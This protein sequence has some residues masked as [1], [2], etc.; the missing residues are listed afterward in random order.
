MYHKLQ[1]FVSKLDVH[2][3]ASPASTFW[4]SIIDTPPS[5]LRVTDGEFQRGRALFL[6]NSVQISQSL[7]FFSLAGGFASPRIV[8]TLEA[9]SYLVPSPEKKLSSASKDRTYRRLL[10]TFQFVLDVMKCFAPESDL[11]GATH[12]LPGGEGWKSIIRVRMLHGIARARVQAKVYHE[13]DVPR[14]LNDVPISQEDISATQ[15]HFPRLFIPH[16]SGP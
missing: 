14:S 1:T 16:P 9:V 5:D 11:D 7:L 8:R 2:D 10:E 3:N 4:K 12:I 13:P 6:D 15:V